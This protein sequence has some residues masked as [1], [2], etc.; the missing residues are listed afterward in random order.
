MGMKSEND[1]AI[2]AEIDSLNRDIQELK[3]TVSS[4]VLVVGH[5]L[6]LQDKIEQKNACGSSST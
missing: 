5:L 4:L 6:K 1:N 3:K 2:A